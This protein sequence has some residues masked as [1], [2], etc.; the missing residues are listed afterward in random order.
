MW[1]MW[2]R[3]MSLEYLRK[4]RDV[5]DLI[6]LSQEVIGSCVIIHIFHQSNFKIPDHLESNL[7]NCSICPKVLKS[8]FQFTVLLYFESSSKTTEVPESCGFKF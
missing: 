2:V 4:S 5:C 6:D 7:I 1:Y 8:V 3:C